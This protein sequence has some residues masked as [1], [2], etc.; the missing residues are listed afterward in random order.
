MTYNVVLVLVG[1]QSD[2]IIHTHTHTHTHMNP[3]F[4]I[5]F[6]YRLLQNIECSFLCYIVVLLVI[7]FMYILSFSCKSHFNYIQTSCFYVE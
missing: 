3:F 7:Y 5:L 2:S 6:C 4:L 1:Q